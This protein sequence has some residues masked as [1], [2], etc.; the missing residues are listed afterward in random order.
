MLL[1]TLLLWTSDLTNVE[2]AGRLDY[3]VSR[4]GVFGWEADDTE[5]IARLERLIAQEIGGSREDI[6][7]EFRLGVRYAFSREGEALEAVRPIGFSQWAAETEISCDR[8]AQEHPTLLRRT[9]DT[10]ARWAQ[11]VKEHTD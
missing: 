7:R 1:L 10:A 9:P 8:I 4:C 6:I 5:R 11:L 2:A 3:V